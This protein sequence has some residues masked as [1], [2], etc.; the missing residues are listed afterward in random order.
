M[1][2]HVVQ[3]EL[4]KS[5]KVASGPMADVTSQTD[6]DRRKGAIHTSGPLDGMKVAAWLAWIH[7]GVYPR[8]QDGLCA[9]QV[10]ECARGG[11]KQKPNSKARDSDHL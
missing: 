6:F 10:K 1:T 4:R 9:C 5:A 2:L 7:D 11:D 8:V 3:F